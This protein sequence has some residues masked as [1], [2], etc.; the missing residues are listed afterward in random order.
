M[1]NSRHT[2]SHG[3]GAEHHSTTETLDKQTLT[4]E[5]V[6]NAVIINTFGESVPMPSEY[7]QGN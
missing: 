2:S 5:S 3:D 1:I 4:G 7:Y 6:Q